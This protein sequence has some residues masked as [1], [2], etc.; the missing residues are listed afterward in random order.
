M[1]G[2]EPNPHRRSRLTAGVLLAAGL[3]AGLTAAVYWTSAPPAARADDDEEQKPDVRA[4]LIAMHTDGTHT[5]VRV[6]QEPCF[7]LAAG[8]SPD[9][10]V[11]GEA[12]TSTWEGVLRVNRRGKYRLAANVQGSVTVE[13]AGKAV[14]SADSAGAAEPVRRSGDEVELEAGFPALRISFSKKAGPARLQLFWEGRGFRTEP[15]PPMAVGHKPE[16]ASP[17]VVEGKLLDRGRHLAEEFSC[18][19]CH[20][21]GPTDKVAAGLAN[22]KAPPLASGMPFQPEWFYHWMGDPQAYRPG[23]PMPQM[24]ADDEAGRAE[25]AVIT[26]YL[27]GNKPAPTPPTNK[28]SASTGER[29]FKTVGCAVCHAAG[30][31]SSA[32]VTLQGL[33]SKHYERTL[34]DFLYDP[35]KHNPHTRM[36][37][38]LPSRGDKEGENLAAYLTKDKLPAYEKP[39]PAPPGKDKLAEMYAAVAPA[40]APPDGFAKLK[41][42]QQ[43]ATLAKALLQARNCTSCH[44]VKDGNKNLPGGGAPGF[45][46][47]AAAGEKGCLSKAP[48]GKAPRFTMTDADRKA[49]AAFVAKGA[50]GAGAPAPVFAARNALEKLN[51][52]GCHQRGTQGGLNQEMVGLLQKYEKAENAEAVMPPSL[53]QVGHKIKVPWMHDVLTAAKRARPWM[54]LRMPQFAKEHV[55]KLAAGLAAADGVAPADTDPPV[56]FDPALVTAGRHLVGKSG[57][58]CISCHDIAGNPAGGTRGPDLAGVV[59]RVRPDWFERWMY[60]PQRLAP[61]TR[62]PTVHL[63]GK[64]SLKDVLDGDLNRQINAMRVY[65]SLG[66]KL[67]LPEGV[68]PPTAGGKNAPLVLPVKDRTVVERCFMREVGAQAIAVGFV[69]GPNV[70]FDAYNCR[71]GYGWTGGFLDMKAMWDGRGGQP[72]RPM[73]A[74][75]WTAPEGFPWALTA[76]AG[77]APDWDKHLADKTVNSHAAQGERPD[78]PRRVHFRGYSLK[79]TPTFR[80]VFEPAEGVQAAFRE[81]VAPLTHGAGVGVA[82]TLEVTLPA[83]QTG[84]F[85]AARTTEPFKAYGAEVS[86]SAPSSELPATAV[87]LVPAGKQTVLLKAA[88]VPAD[89]KWV[90]TNGK[91]AKDRDVRTAML[92]V[93]ASGKLRLEVW[94]PYRSDPAVVEQLVKH[95]TGQ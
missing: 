95:V 56:T 52:I 51:C 29:V 87:L 21:A 61:G 12:F 6:E 85:L 44:E 36:P 68:T 7:V 80:Y 78:H 49:V 45:A 4:G 75:F 11:A 46:V 73:G 91:D 1:T 71:L 86:D 5:A 48:A 38:L 57:F 25:R 94:S 34:T 63:D 17:A 20:Q 70:A 65:L 35:A 72:A 60:D 69:G 14:L 24:F 22:R 15:L 37:N 16:Q 67:P 64:S 74:G 62:M 92:R 2:T 76:S 31:G 88:E 26:A 3:A 32:H 84:W 90:L 23:T 30:S 53:T 10:R 41:P 89:A 9:P 54:S 19:A 79:P 13:V 55:G 83:G 8:E 58:G 93:P 39:A 82:R 59:E 40:G 28:A 47:L 50:A 18:T 27:A 43:V 81:A 42:D 33:G 77:E 66:E